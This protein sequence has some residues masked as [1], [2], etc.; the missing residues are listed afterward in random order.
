M[1]YRMNMLKAV[2]SFILKPFETHH[3]W[4]SNKPR[5]K[6]GALSAA[7]LP[8]RVVKGEELQD[9]CE[10]SLGELFE[11]RFTVNTIETHSK[12]PFNQ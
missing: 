2:L 9:R 7:G 1:G 6:E 11:W 10:L 4:F 3:S 8:S 5:P 12:Q